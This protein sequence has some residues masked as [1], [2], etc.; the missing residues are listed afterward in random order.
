MALDI[1]I[2]QTIFGRN[3]N[4]ATD[5]THNNYHNHHKDLISVRF[6]SSIQ[7]R[8][9]FLLFFIAQDIIAVVVHTFYGVLFYFYF[10]HSFWKSDTERKKMEKAIILDSEFPFVFLHY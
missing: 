9:T 4:A 10:F 8:F 2:L 7:F 5:K 3:I 6:T 1:F